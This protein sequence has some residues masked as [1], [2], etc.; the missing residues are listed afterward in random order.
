[1]S[2]HIVAFAAPQE[3]CLLDAA[4]TPAQPPSELLIFPFGPV[5]TLKGTFQ[6]T[7]RSAELVLAQWARLG[8]DIGFD[9]EHDLFSKD[10]PGKQREAAGWGKVEVRDSGLWITGIRWTPEAAAKIVALAFRYLSPAL[11]SDKRTAEVIGLENVALTNY[12]ATLAAPPIVLSLFHLLG[13]MNNDTQDQ[14]HAT[15]AAGLRKGCSTLLGAAQKCAESDHP[16]LKEV[17]GKL[18]GAMPEA[19]AQLT[20]AFPALQGAEDQPDAELSA[21]QQIRVAVEQVTGVTEGHVGALLA[22]KAS[23]TQK[24]QAATDTTAAKHAAQLQRLI[25]VTRQVKPAERDHYAKLSLADLQTFERLAPRVGPVPATEEHGAAGALLSQ[26]P[27]DGP[28]AD[29]DDLFKQIRRIP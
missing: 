4:G 25:E 11:R 3:I 28:D 24:T 14:K 15:L 13:D 7:R 5:R 23:A 22:L 18:A 1:M 29:V 20:A 8:R 2:G 27:A 26:R 16:G 6:F 12:P 17:G 19:V 9:Y 10:V 21:L